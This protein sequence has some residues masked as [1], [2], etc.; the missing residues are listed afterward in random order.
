MSNC[1]VTIMTEKLEEL[2]AAA[3]RALEKTAEMIHTE[4]EQAQVMPFRKGHLQD[5][6]TF[7]DTSASA[8][9]HVDLVSSTPYARRLYYHPEYSFNREENPN[10]GAAWFAPWAEGGEHEDL[11]A[12]TFAAL[13]K[14]EAGL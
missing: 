1:K 7:V 8:Q 3:I 11:A 9:G 13:F 2:D 14:R 10:A 6:S 5:E 12:V 4:V